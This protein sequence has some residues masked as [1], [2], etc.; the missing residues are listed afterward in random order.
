MHAIGEGTIPAAS[1][2]RVWLHLLRFPTHAAFD[3][4]V[5]L[6]GSAALTCEHLACSLACNGRAKT[7]GRTTAWTSQ[8]VRAQTPARFAVAKRPDRLEWRQRGATS[9]FVRSE[10]ART[11]LPSVTGARGRAAGR[12]THKAV[13][14]VG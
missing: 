1:G 4:T 10:A 11:E 3:S 12:V 9:G 14:A 6:V 5:L 7:L 8:D 2:R 13:K